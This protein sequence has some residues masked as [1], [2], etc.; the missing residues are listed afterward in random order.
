V[1]TPSVNATEVVDVEEEKDDD[2]VE[3]AGQEAID[4]EQHVE[5]DGEQDDEDEDDDMP[6]RSKNEA[7]RSDKTVDD[8]DVLLSIKYQPSNQ[9]LMP[10]VADVEAVADHNNDMEVEIVGEK[11]AEMESKFDDNSLE[12]FGVDGQSFAIEDVGKTTRIVV[13]ALY[14][15]ISNLSSACQLQPKTS[16]SFKCICRLSP[17]VSFQQTRTRNGCR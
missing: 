13:Q 14:R 15:S 1:H 7:L 4:E 16:L 3:S 11:P 5:K 17:P 10:T 9:D 12:Y 2:V 6:L 8:D